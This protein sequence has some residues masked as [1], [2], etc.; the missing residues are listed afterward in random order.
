MLLLLLL[1]LLMMCEF[2]ESTLFIV[3]HAMLNSF[4]SCHII[5]TI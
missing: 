5:R 2:V 4:L 3:I 1:L